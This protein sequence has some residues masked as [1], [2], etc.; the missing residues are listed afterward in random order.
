MANSSLPDHFDWRNKDGVNWMTPVKN[1]NP[2]GHYCGS[3]WAFA[4]VGVTEALYNISY[5]NPDLDLDLSE[6]YLVSDCFPAGNCQIVGP[7]DKAL[8]FIRD[9]GIP[10][11]S[12][13]PYIGNNSS[14][15][16]KCSDWSSRLRRIDETGAVESSIEAIRQA[17]VEKGPLVAV[18]GFSS[19]PPTGG[20]VDSNGIYR[21]TNDNSRN[22]VVILVGYDVAGEYWIVKNSYGTSFQDGGYFKVGWGE[23][24]IEVMVYYA[25]L[26][27]PVNTYAAI[28]VGAHSATLN[29]ELTSF[30][31]AS[32]A[33][34]SFEWA[35]DA[36]YTSH[37][38][39]YNNQSNAQTLSSTGIF[40]S[41]PTGLSPDTTYHFRAKAVIDGTAYG[42]DMTFTT[43]EAVPPAVTTD[44]TTTVGA[45]SATLNGTLTCLGT[46]SLLQVSFE[47]A[48]DA[49][50]MSHDNS[51]N[52]QSSTQT[53]STTGIFSANITGLSPGTTYHF[54]AKAGGDGTAYGGD[55]ILITEEAVP[56][57]VTTDGTTDVGAHSATLNGTLTSLGTASS[58][59]I[60]FR[61]GLTTSYENET[62]AQIVMGNGPF[63]A[64][65][66]GL[67]PGTTYHFMAKAGGDGTAH[68]D[69]MAF[70]TEGGIPPAVTT[71]GTTDVGAHSATLNGT[72]TSLGTASSVQIYFRWGLTTS[73]ENETDAQIVVGNGPF[74]ANITGLSPGTTY[75]FMA[76]AG[77]DGTTYGDDMV[78]T[79]EGGI[80]PAV[81]TDAAANVGA[82]SATINGDLTS[83]G[84]ASSV[85]VFF[86]WGL[87]GYDNETTPQTM[88]ANGSFG[89]NLD[90]LATGT[91]Y[92]FR[93]VAV[94]DGT[95]YGSDLIFTTA[96]SAPPMVTTNAATGVGTNSATLNGD[97]TSLGTA[98]SAQVS[99]EWATDAYYTSHGNSYDN[100]TNTQTMSTT[101]IFSSNPTGLSPGTT[102]HFRAKA[103]GDGT[104]YSADMTFTTTSPLSVT[105]N[106]ATNLTSTSAI[107]NGYLNSLGGA[108]SAT[109]S[110]QI[111]TTTSY[112]RE[113]G[114]QTVTSVGT[115]SFN[116]TGLS[117]GRTYHFR[118]KTVAGGTTAYGSDM[119]VT[120]VGGTLS[121]T[122][123]A[124][125]YV[126]TNSAT[127]NGYLNSLGGASSA[128]VSFQWGLNISYGNETT[129]QT[130]TTTSAF[131][132]NL[133]IL[134]PG[135]TYHYRAK[136]V[137]GSTT[138]Y[139]ADM[140][141]TTGTSGTPPEVRT[142][143]ATSITRTS[144]T[145][146]GYLL[147]LGSA[148]SVTVSFQVGRTT[149]YTGEVGS[150]IMTSAAPF[151]YNFAGFYRGTTYHF[152][153]K[154]VAG[155]V[156]V[157][158]ADMVFTTSN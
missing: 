46:A 135:T 107:L 89:T 44:G 82:R 150:Q 7:P 2:Q 113:V 19:S 77:G 144:A 75:H 53:L 102:Y 34:A 139:G 104:A 54:M 80:P 117:P 153:A 24:G 10:D 94:G 156:T 90:S 134:A 92:L 103:V 78:F 137:A 124:A 16:G 121:V 108:S 42:A 17:L 66:T 111:G 119:T 28:D 15:S 41:N 97:L 143:P 118:A 36:Y 25:S 158:G 31:I 62:D 60:H 1:Q 91:T 109:V 138:V 93:A 157:Y 50:Y 4:S 59:Q 5:R 67:S 40:S 65:I 14:C 32:S 141:F 35:T 122:T 6:E 88:N 69:D 20:Y 48:T 116:L 96:V 68:G 13:F 126:L 71:D 56:P 37:G 27:A 9:S 127:L 86:Q 132:V 133:S 58:V 100:Q 99:F 101:G 142:D 74:S 123:T 76:K 110:F 115:F 72:L 11:E 87:T 125:T 3:C 131:D 155:G 149:S 18:M 84:T 52:N 61:W 21:C 47:W 38:D 114:S 22:H 70:T 136:A 146:N 49:Y 151:S 148:S 63:S 79:T 23:C 106:A 140:M 120:T 147:S 145:L 57:A 26:N 29:G 112:S 30:G 152:R 45:H 64:N 98:S 105:T 8:Q 12:C 33:Q 85:Q 55:M 51:Y 39:S 73:Y 130:R 154:A 81:T 43:E 95:T 83:L 128:Q 129:P